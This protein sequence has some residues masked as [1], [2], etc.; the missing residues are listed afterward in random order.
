[1]T[2]IDGRVIGKGRPEEVTRRLIR[3][4]AEYVKG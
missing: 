2:R 4:F 1:V 3:A